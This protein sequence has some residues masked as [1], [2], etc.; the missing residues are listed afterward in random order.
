MNDMI[1]LLARI[2]TILYL[3]S[4]VGSLLIG[5]I[6]MKVAFEEGSYIHLALGAILL[7]FAIVTFFLY[8]NGTN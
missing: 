3:V 1:N 4:F 6:S 5:L 2:G 8:I 7:Y